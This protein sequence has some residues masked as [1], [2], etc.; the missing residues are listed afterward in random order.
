[1][2]FVSW[3]KTSN[4]IKKTE[5]KVN[6]N[7]HFLA[8]VIKKYKSAQMSSMKMIGDCLGKN[9]ALTQKTKSELK[10]TIYFCNGFETCF[11]CK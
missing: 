9:D 1:M 3:G 2:V 6:F 4:L 7:E 5:K 11:F 8:K 10:E